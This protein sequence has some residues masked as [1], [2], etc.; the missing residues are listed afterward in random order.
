MSNFWVDVGF[1][2]DYNPSMVLHSPRPQFIAKHIIR[3]HVVWDYTKLG[4]D[5]VQLDR[6][7][8]FHDSEPGR[9]SYNKVARTREATQTLGIGGGRTIE[10]DRE[11]F[12]LRETTG[13]ANP[14]DPTQPGTLS[15]SIKNLMTAKQRLLDL[16]NLQ[17]FNDSIGSS[18]LATDFL[19]WEDRVYILEL[20]STTQQYNPSGFADG[21]T[22]D[23]NN[24]NSEP[25]RITVKDLDEILVRL[26]SN[27]NNAIP[28]EDG[29]FGCMLSSRALSHLKRDPEFQKI[30]TEV[31]GLPASMVMMPMQY[32]PMSPEPPQIQYGA[33]PTMMNGFYSTP[34]QGGLY[35]GQTI[36]EQIMP[37]G[38]V[39]NGFR[40]FVSENIPTVE[41]SLTYS[42]VPAGSGITSGAADRTAENVIFFGQEAL[43]VAIGGA[44]PQIKIH[45]NTDFGR[46]IHLIW[47]HFGEC[48][49]LQD[50]FVIVARSY[51]N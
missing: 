26:R 24:H 46:H 40:F 22:V 45:E 34:Y 10:K 3:P 36:N 25:P 51:N 38:F 29:N 18:R 16:G 37:I 31:G 4:G 28:F 49:L 32:G 21:A 27:P 44:G 47:Q 43:G 6:Y 12:K 14:E 35:A 9:E 2:H 19:M 1:P 15:V 7:A 11:F 33:T 8:W 5:V 30:A 41:V 50:K 23:L 13:P 20:L 39:F 48:K 42:N 17:M